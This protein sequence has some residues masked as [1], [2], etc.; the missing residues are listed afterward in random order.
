MIG[1]TGEIPDCAVDSARVE[2]AR[3]KVPWG[4]GTPIHRWATG[5][6]G[7]ITRLW[8]ER[9]LPSLKSIRG[10]DRSKG[11][12]DDSKEPASAEEPTARATRRLQEHLKL[13]EYEAAIAIYKNARRRFPD[14]QP[15]ERAYLELVQGIVNLA[16][17]EVAVEIIPEYLAR[18]QKPDVRVR[19]KLAQ[20]LI[21]HR[22]RPT[23]AL[24]V[25][26]AIPAGSLSESLEATRADIVKRATAMIEDGIVEIDDDPR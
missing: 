3:M 2:E 11:S 21:R 23:K 24:E 6:A 17:W 9:R 20:I 12:K 18:S 10:E 5:T 19:L 4:N 8:V 16:N 26:A 7:K 22:S 13:K 14:W 25:L 15:P 1:N